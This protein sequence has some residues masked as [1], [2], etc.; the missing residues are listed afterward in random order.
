MGGFTHHCGILHWE[1]YGWVVFE[2]ISVVDLNA[3]N[4]L[5]NSLHTDLYNAIDQS[6][7]CAVKSGSR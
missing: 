4:E 5:F 3:Y 1:V 2:T 6:M 7:L